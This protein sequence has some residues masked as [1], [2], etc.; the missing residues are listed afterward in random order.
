MRSKFA[1]RRPFKARA[2][3]RLEQEIEVSLPLKG[4]LPDVNRL[5]SSQDLADA[6]CAQIRMQINLA[7]AK[8]I[9]RDTTRDEAEKNVA[10]LVGCLELARIANWPFYLQQ[11]LIRIIE[12][13]RSLSNG[14]RDPMLEP[15]Y[16]ASGRAAPA[17]ERLR[18]YCALAVQ[19]K[20]RLDGASS[21]DARMSFLKDLEHAIELDSSSRK[22]EVLFPARGRQVADG[23]KRR[24]KLLDEW[25]KPRAIN[26][27]SK[28]VLP[29]YKIWSKQLQNCPSES[30]REAYLVAL[31]FAALQAKSLLEVRG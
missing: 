9:E 30:H 20:R 11:R 14:I 15:K 31:S 29:V 26:R 28:L 3:K 7:N 6:I 13:L 18:M 8:A 27:L 25:S 2:T 12:A 22:W 1:R 19:A 21:K 5:W 24:C 16:P 10:T 23:E 4:D 17:V